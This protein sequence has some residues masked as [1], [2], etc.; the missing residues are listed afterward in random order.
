MRCRLLN[1]VA[2]AACLIA[3]GWPTP[4][5]ADGGVIRLSETTD[6]FRVTVLTAPTPFRAGPVDVS[7]LVQDARTG[8]V[9]P[10]AKVTLRLFARDNPSEIRQYAATT[11][12]AT[13]K[14]FYSA[15]FD[16]PAPGW[17]TL[18]T[19]VERAQK[20]ARVSFQMEAA[21]PLPRWAGFWPWFTWPFLTVA[22]FAFHQV[23][24]FNRIRSQPKREPRPSH[25]LRRG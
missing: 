18:E 10:D 7:V 15:L 13:N 25:S 3:S 8:E 12:A 11:A 24:A 1:M 20:T 22:L 16:L 4:A 14:L 5:F 6:A 17:W 19:D 2:A 21:G 9:V 23:L